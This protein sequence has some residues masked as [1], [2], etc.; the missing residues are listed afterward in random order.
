VYRFKTFV[1]VFCRLYLF[2]IALHPK[3][4]GYLICDNE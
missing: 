4:I 3:I 2:L 1:F